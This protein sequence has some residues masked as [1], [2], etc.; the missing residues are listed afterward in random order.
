MKGWLSGATL[1]REN[2]EK[3]FELNLSGGAP[4]EKTAP[5]KD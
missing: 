3:M 4:P 2:F 5:G 1:E